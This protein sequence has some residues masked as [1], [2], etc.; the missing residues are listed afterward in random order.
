MTT[1]WFKKDSSLDELK[2]E[3]RKLLKK[4]HP[5][6]GGDTKTAQEI[7]NEYEKL[8]RYAVDTGFAYYQAEREKSGKSTYEADLTPFYDILK[9]VAEL[10]EHVIIKDIHAWARILQE[11]DEVRRLGYTIV[12]IVREREKVWN[13]LLKW[14]NVPD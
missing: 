6:H 13:D 10:K 11:A 9:K 14:A 4:Y 2:H 1:K 5:D 3:Y 8:I 12:A 7:I